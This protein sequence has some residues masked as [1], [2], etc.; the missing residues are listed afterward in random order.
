MITGSQVLQNDSIPI[1]GPDFVSHACV[2]STDNTIS[3][4]I[5]E[6][7]RK[8]KDIVRTGIPESLMP[9]KCSIYAEHKCEFG[10]SQMSPPSVGYVFDYKIPCSIYVYY[11]GVEDQKGEI[12][13]C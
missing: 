3:C 7:T 12:S 2:E 6:Y 8:V 4:L 9:V 13:E 10:L 1:D 11:T 5:S